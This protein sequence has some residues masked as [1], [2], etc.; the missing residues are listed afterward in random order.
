MN[1][2]WTSCKNKA[3]LPLVQGTTDIYSS[4]LTYLIASGNTWSPRPVL[5]SYSVFTSKLAEKNKQHLLGE[6]SPD[7]IFFNL[8]P[9]DGRLPSLED[10]ASWPILMSHYQL[11]QTINH[12]LLLQK[13]SPEPNGTSF[14]EKPIIPISSEHHSFGEVVLVPDTSQP[15]FAEITIK[16]TLLGYLAT[17]I[18]APSTL[19]VQV[20]LKNGIWKKYRLITNMAQSGFLLS[21]LIEST[22]EFASLFDKNKNLAAKKIKAFSINTSK[23]NSWQWNTEYKVRLN[24]TVN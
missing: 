12:F 22:D 10:G 20:E 13:K 7:T 5:Q 18:L 15:V 14:T 3:G 6:N 11:S 19:Q 4:N 9:I 8:E 1:Y 21:P 24:L 17:L 2:P 23:G 16:P